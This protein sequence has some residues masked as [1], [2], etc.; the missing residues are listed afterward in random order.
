MP[1]RIKEKVFKTGCCQRKFSLKEA[2][3]KIQ[4]TC[5]IATINDKLKIRKNSISKRV[6]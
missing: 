6:L 2:F 3:V 4:L 5:L 1:I